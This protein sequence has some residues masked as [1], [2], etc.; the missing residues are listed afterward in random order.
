MRLTMQRPMHQMGGFPESWLKK[1][2]K[3]RFAIDTVLKLVPGFLDEFKT[4]A[5]SYQKYI[6]HST[7]VLC[8]YLFDNNLYWSNRQNGTVCCK[9]RHPHSLKKQP[10]L[11]HMVLLREILS[12]YVVY[13]M[14]FDEIAKSQKKEVKMKSLGS[15][16]TQFELRKSHFYR[17]HSRD[18]ARFC[19]SQ[20][21]KLVMLLN[22]TQII[23]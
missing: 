10:G 19:F 3:S 18:Q 12:T 11:D 21:D 15:A 22:Q 5:V 9:S 14:K 23:M 16:L 8:E 6:L 7:H 4:I 2:R 13:R 1:G 17:A 20:M